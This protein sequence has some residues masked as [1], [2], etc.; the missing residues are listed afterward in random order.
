M[1]TPKPQTPAESGLQDSVDQ[2]TPKSEDAPSTGT[3]CHPK[4]YRE[5]EFLIDNLLV[6]I[7][8]II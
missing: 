1:P 6:R 5:R 4:P 8:F 2:F 3:G 7:H